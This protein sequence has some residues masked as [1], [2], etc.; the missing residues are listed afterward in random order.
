[1]QITDPVTRYRVSPAFLAIV[2]AI[3]SAALVTC[4]PRREL[5]SALPVSFSSPKRFASLFSLFSLFGLFFDV[6]LTPKQG[7]SAMCARCC[8]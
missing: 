8:S 5:Y 1:M 4:V 7:I 3:L 2:V 6:A